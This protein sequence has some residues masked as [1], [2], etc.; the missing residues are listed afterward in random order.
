MFGGSELRKRV[1]KI[2]H[3]MWKAAVASESG[4]EGSRCPKGWR[5]GLVIPLWKKTGSRRDKNTYRGITLLSVGSKLLARILASR[6]ERWSEAWLHENQCRFRRNRGVDDVL[7]VSRRVLEEI[8]RLAGDDW[9]TLSFF[10]IEKAYPRVCKAALWE[11]LRRRGCDP[12]L[13]KIFKALHHHTDYCVKVH[14]GVS[15][16]W[17]PDRGLREG[18]P[19]S[20]PCLMCTTT[21]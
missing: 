3:K 16:A 2:V 21:R 17:N 4:L 15:T 7:Q 1:F 14:G 8:T 9:Y 12:R 10:D 20:L 11:V 13:V 18:C 5:I 19:S 6:V